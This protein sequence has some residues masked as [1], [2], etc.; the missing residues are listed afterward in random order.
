[1]TFAFFGDFY[2]K[3]PV[4]CLI[5]ILVLICTLVSLFNKKALF[6]FMLHPY[7]IVRQKEYYR[8]LTADLFNAD[9][10]H[11]ALN[12]FMLYVFCS[13]LE[14]SLRRQ[15]SYG[16][17]IFAGIYWGSLLF[18]SFI[19]TLRHFRDYNYTSTGTSGSI[20]GCMFAFIVIAPNFGVYDLPGIGEVKNIY[21]GLAYILAMII[22]QRRKNEERVN[23]EFHFYGALFGV[24]TGL[25]I[26]FA[27]K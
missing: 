11:L 24:I 17:L 27:Y 1:M 22:Y 8:I 23:H 6:A 13:D 3:S 2:S 5:S 21:G 10:L 25:L 14:E 19:V 4:T 7:S 16:S 26:Y 9:L 12:E 18:A 15:G 20:M